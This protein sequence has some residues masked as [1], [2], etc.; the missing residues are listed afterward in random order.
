MLV[1]FMADQSF[2]GEV[3]A[4]NI[5]NDTPPYR[6]MVSPT[7]PNSSWQYLIV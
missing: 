2:G 1:S 3:E 5:A 7:F 6:L 4:L